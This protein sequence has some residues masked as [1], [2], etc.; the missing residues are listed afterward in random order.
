MICFVI[1]EDIVAIIVDKNC[2]GWQ[3][4]RITLLPLNRTELVIY[5]KSYTAGM[6][7]P[8][9]HRRDFF[10]SNPETL[11]GRKGKVTQLCLGIPSLLEITNFL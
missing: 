10:I 11:S 5:G 3:K 4:Q 2:S 9:A 6:L 8:K 7:C 1:R